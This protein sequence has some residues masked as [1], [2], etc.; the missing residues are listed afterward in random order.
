MPPYDSGWGR[1]APWNPGRGPGP[2]MGPR[3]GGY[4]RDFGPR[5]GF[6]GP[7]P[8][9]DA[10]PSYGREMEFEDTDGEWTSGP[11]HGPAR[12]G[13]G[14][15]HQRLR[16]RRR[17]DDELKKEV[18]DALFYDTWVDSEAIAVEVSDGVV[19][20]RGELPDYQEVRYATDDAWDVEGVHGVHS[21]LV[22]NSARRP[23]RDGMPRRDASPNR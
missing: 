7:G 22:V 6:G 17:P 4:G 3:P 21:Q 15:Y 11:V 20:L 13:L 5:G 14:P 10:E 19:T 16:S 9:Y 12:Y 1:P 2:G 18:E 23:P 8:E